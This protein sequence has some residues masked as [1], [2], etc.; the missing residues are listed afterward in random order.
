M[1]I[2]PIVLTLVLVGA[3][4]AV[5][6]TA[7]APDGERIYTQNCARCHD[8]NTP[9]LL[10]AAPIQ[11]YSAERIY[12]ALTYSFMVRQ[13]AG[14]SKDEKRAVA[15]YVSGSPGGSL[16]DPLDQIPQ[17]AYCSA[18]G[19]ATGDPLAGPTWPPCAPALSKMATNGS[20]MAPKSGHRAPTK[21]IGAF[22]SPGP[23]PMSPS[24]KA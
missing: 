17:T 6:A 7:Q 19:A 15:E 2:V 20:S 5:G 16:R 8:G 1:R 21:P 22:W 24:I 9:Q 11:E 14:L 12:E 3:V 13:A 18:E 23:T 4:R 10:T